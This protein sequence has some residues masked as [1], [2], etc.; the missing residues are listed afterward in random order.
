MEPIA[1]RRA[2]WAGHVESWR[3]CELTQ[4]A[5]C[6]GHALS[7]QTI[8]A[9]I[10]RCNPKPAADLGFIRSELHS[11]TAIISTSAPSCRSRNPDH[12][13]PGLLPQSGH[14]L[15]INPRLRATTDHRPASGLKTPRW[16]GPHR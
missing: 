7:P 12:G 13:C 3:N 11:G 16:H 15:K 5:Y 6:R 4:A 1:V 10:K 2:R 9:W 8:T 14:T